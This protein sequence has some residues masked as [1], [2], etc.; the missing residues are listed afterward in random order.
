MLGEECYWREDDE[1]DDGGE[2]PSSPSL[3]FDIPL[4]PI[5][6]RKSSGPSSCVIKERNTHR[7]AYRPQPYNPLLFANRQPKAEAEHA[8]GFGGG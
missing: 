2:C 3:D 8:V 4:R 6:R 5:E 7:L 1:E